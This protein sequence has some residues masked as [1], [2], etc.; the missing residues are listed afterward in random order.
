MNDQEVNKQATKTRKKRVLCVRDLIE[1]KQ[2]LQ[3]RKKVS[4]RA[5]I[6]SVFGLVFAFCTNVG[7]HNIFSVSLI[8][9]VRFVAMFIICIQINKQFIEKYL[10]HNCR[11]IVHAQEE[12]NK[13]Q[14]RISNE[15]VQSGGIGSNSNVYF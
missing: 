7:E 14:H 6:L 2:K 8:S 12:R 13:N 1:S 15:S 10:H 11:N 4:V 3:Q 9:V 5:S